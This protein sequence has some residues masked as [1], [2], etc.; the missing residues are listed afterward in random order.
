MLSTALLPAQ[1]VLGNGEPDPAWPT[2]HGWY[3]AAFGING[4]APPAAGD[5]VGLWADRSVA[6]HDLDQVLTAASE[7]PTWRAGDANGLPAL[8]FDGDDAIWALE[9]TFGQIPEDRTVFVVLRVEPGGDH[10]YVL[11]SSSSFGRNA[12]LTG[13]AGFHPGRWQ[14]Q[15]G[16]DTILS[17]DVGYESWQVHTLELGNGFQQHFRDGVLQATGAAGLQALRGLTL[18]A[19]YSLE[20]FFRGGIAEVLVYAQLLPQADRE[21]VEGYLRRKYLEPR[22]RFEP[23]KAGAGE[24]LLLQVSG[25]TP[26]AAVF[27]GA[28]TTGPGPW[29]SPWGTLMLTPPIHPIPPC[30]ADGA[31]L[32]V[33]TAWI[34]EDL[35]GRTLWIQAYDQGSG[36]L[37]TL[38]EAPIL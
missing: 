22:P 34:P 3:D 17:T 23:F 5:P 15:T 36:R 14:I 2:L 19:R 37:S 12:F 10:G 25:C 20:D 38:G 31:G 29:P 6:G 32:A 9:T 1:V 27:F 28:S 11:D 30:G 8:A 33:Q 21:A 16:M 13:Q 35:Q 7:R 26:Y 24:P 18:G 4:G